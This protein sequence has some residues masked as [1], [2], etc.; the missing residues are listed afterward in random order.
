[1]RDLAVVPN[2][3]PRVIT[4]TRLL[5][6]RGVFRYGFIFI[7]DAALPP[8][9]G[10]PLAAESPGRLVVLA[11]LWLDTFRAAKCR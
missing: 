7:R 9:V 3:V 6:C 5:R 8:T 10:L 1:M 4:L 2:V 11:S